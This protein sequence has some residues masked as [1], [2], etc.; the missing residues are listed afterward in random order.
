M[1][2]Q[3]QWRRGNTAQTAAFTGALAEITVDTDKKTLVVHDGVTLGGFPLSSGNAS[4]NN[5]ISITSAYNHTNSAFIQANAAFA[6]ANAAL[7]CCDTTNS[8]FAKANTAND[9]AIGA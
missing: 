3:I 5:T 9:T 8:A 7:L 4:T 1:A 2:T 6:A